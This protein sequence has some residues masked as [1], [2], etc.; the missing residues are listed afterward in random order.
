MGRLRRLFD[1][2]TVGDDAMAGLV[3]GIESVPD[4]LASGLLAG[5]NPVAGL[6]AYLYGAVSAAFF[7]STA[8]MAVQGTGAMAIIVADIEAVHSSDDP[9]RTLVTLS[10]LTGIAMILAGLLKFGAMLRFVSNSVMTG[11]ISAVG[12]NIVLGQVGD[13][14]GYASDGASRVTRAL[15]TVFR[16]WRIDFWTLAVG[17]VTIVL[18]IMLR[19]TKLGALGLV[20]AIGAGSA[21]AGF[22]SLFDIEVQLV[23]NI[24]EV[25]GALP[26]ITMP[27]FSDIPVLVV[28]AI[29]LAF[30]GLVQGAGVTA[31]FPN[32][33]GSP[34][35]VSQDF[36]GQGAGNVA[37]GLFQG[38]PVG[39]SMSASSLV[40]S[41]GA[42]TRAALVFTGVVMALVILLFA[43]VVEY[44][45]MPSLAGLLIVVGIETVKPANIVS[46]WKTGSVQASA[47]TVTLVLTLLIPLQFAVLV[48]MGVS[49]IL[50]I[51][52]QSNQIVARR[53]ELDDE[54]RIREVAPPKTVPPEEV[55]V[56]QPYGS[57]FFAAAP[58]FE[59]E[60]PTVTDESVHSVVIIRLRGKSDIG[61]SLIDVLGRYA[62]A[63]SEV[64]SKLMIVTDSDRI[65]TQL[66]VTGATEFIGKDNIYASTEWLTAT[67][68]R[69]ADDAE[70]WIAAQRSDGNSEEDA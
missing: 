36:I 4:G 51:V 68:R 1:R 28:P 5:L 43:G 47:M 6:Y 41:A 21:F 33:D 66:D 35:D 55:L 42:K 40:V 10:L 32:V 11:F 60:L 54:G 20:V 69:A 25:P 18:I 49:M 56:I 29:S 23:G 58:L 61:S 15:D 57:L 8:F 38:M 53:M 37:S 70:D 63:L 19:E 31:S 13:F 52:R 39:G 14:T 44:I 26:F 50:Y 59:E 17:V 2:K 7:T 45:A 27:S 34:S 12:I 9:V 30:V 3:L 65:R 62:Q 16:F 24:A 67:V 22:L 64:E 46:V 48:G